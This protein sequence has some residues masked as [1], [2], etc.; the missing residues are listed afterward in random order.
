[1]IA[2]SA[3][4]SLVAICGIAA[5]LAPSTAMADPA[6]AEALFREGRRLLDEGKTD[7]ACLKLAESQAQDPSS[8]TLLN[9][10]LC[11]EMQHKI[12]TAWSDYVSA[13]RYARDQGR[14]D[15]AAAAEKKAAQLEVRLP[16]LTV[17]A[18][19]P[20]AGLAIERGGHRLGPGAL[21]S[22]VPLDPGSYMVTASAPGH[23]TW[24]ATIDVAEA[25]SKT[26]Q[27]PE[28]EAEAPA[29]TEGSA[30]SRG[31][32]AIAPVPTSEPPPPAVVPPPASR[33]A[34]LGWVIGGT[35]VAAIAVGAAFGFS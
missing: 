20:A 28:L 3:I 9:L 18:A 12:A 14:A 15:R 22:A 6:T 16:H 19:S 32:P 7:E 13:A 5:L 31:S 34:A 26:V 24:K 23:K 11:H 29:A 4:G 17:T 1:M 2:P 30:A 27:V 25:E 8:G 21:G 33:G 10:G 35:G